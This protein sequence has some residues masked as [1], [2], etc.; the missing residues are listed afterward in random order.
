[1]DCT[2]YS[3][4]FFQ[5][6]MVYIFCF[7]SPSGPSSLGCSL[8]GGVEDRRGNRKSFFGRRPLKPC[9]WRA[10]MI[11]DWRVSSRRWCCWGMLSLIAAC[12]AV[13]TK[14]PRCLHR[15]LCG[16]EEVIA[17]GVVLPGVEPC[18]LGRRS[19]PHDAAGD[20]RVGHH[21]MSDSVWFLV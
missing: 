10:G 21:E 6:G 1:M 17:Y 14:R 13:G 3:F 15:P 19:R 7:K 16:C 11:L 2:G 4:F 5:P 12:C 9:A 18:F 8:V 20:T